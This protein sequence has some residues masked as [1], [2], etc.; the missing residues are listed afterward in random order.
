MMCLWWLTLRTTPW[1]VGTGW[2]TAAGLGRALR[3]GWAAE[4]SWT[5]SAPETSL[6]FPPNIWAEKNVPLHSLL[7]TRR[8]LGSA[9][10]L[11]RTVLKMTFAQKGASRENWCIFIQTHLLQKN[12]S[13]LRQPHL[14]MGTSDLV[15]LA[16]VKTTGKLRTAWDKQVN[17]KTK[18]T[19]GKCS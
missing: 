16:P 6:L 17:G 12:G 3:G 19:D 2:G 18:F 8:A 14:L 1:E 9:S 15:S 5:P 13:T 7:H 10:A 11:E 4:P